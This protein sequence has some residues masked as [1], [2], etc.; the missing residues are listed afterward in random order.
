MSH[1]VQRCLVLALSIPN[2]PAI[3]ITLK[4]PSKIFAIRISMNN[5]TSIKLTESRSPRS[6]GIL[7]LLEKRSRTQSNAVDR[8]LLHVACLNMQSV[9]T[10]EAASHLRRKCQHVT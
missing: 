2:F 6:T 8:A 3:L 10:E 5:D 9:V 4:M 7:C 1:V